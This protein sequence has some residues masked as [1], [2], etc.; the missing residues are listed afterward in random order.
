MEPGTVEKPSLFNI[1]AE[2][3]VLGAIILN[4]DHLGK[5]SDIIKDENFYE[6]IHQRIFNYIV[7]SAMRSN[8][9]AD[10]VTL[11][12]FF[13]N[14]ELIREIGG[15]NYLS[16]LLKMGTGV[17]NV[18]DYASIIKDLYMK[19]QLVL[20]G[21]NVVEK[22]Y[23][24]IM[25]EA[26]QKQI[27][28]AESR[29]FNLSYL[30]EATK[31]FVGIVSPLAE[32]I[33]KAKVAM[34]RDSSVSGIPTD[35]IDLDRLLGGFQGSDLV[36]IAG[37]PSMGKSALA[38]N[39]AYNAAK[40]FDNEFRE[41]KSNIKRTV[42]FFSLEMP[43]DQIASRIL[44]SETAI[45]AQKFR[46]GEIEREDFD[47][48]VKSADYISKL[49]L[50]IDDTPALS[51]AAIRTRIRRMVR[52]KNLSIVVVDYLQLAQGMTAQSKSN[53]VLEIGEITM[54]LKAIAKEF[55]MPVIALSQL[56]RSVEQ[57]E[58][59]KPQLSDL[60]ESGSIEQDADIVMF[61]YREEYYWERK[62]P[63][64][65]D[66][67]IHEWMAKM[68]EVRN[69]C[70]VIVAKHRNGPIGNITLR[71]DASIGKFDNYAGQY[72]KVE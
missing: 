52:Q 29:L 10:S 45:N 34:E 71:F 35:Y 31:G 11:K 30:G 50:Y 2:Q 32:T 72:D 70:E 33:H 66:P 49:P 12:L 25:G 4:N 42:G 67:K 15:S 26:A 58:D 48:I 13:D 1:E 62:K 51:I 60:R 54:G 64:D 37:R 20:I 36:I 17:I 68:S 6:P 22:A 63:S 65:G 16:I 27:E 55:N 61:V 23:T 43:A 18:S 41:G 46:T 39:F 5:V 7:Q 38:I 24:N 9:V 53:R 28:D 8:I 40:F 21:E 19:R 14:D 44:S 3:V 56:S 47:K 69:K 57:R 59:K